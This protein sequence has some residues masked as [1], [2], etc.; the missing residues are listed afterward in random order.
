MRKILA[1][2]GIIL[3]VLGLFLFSLYNF[4]QK[5]NNIDYK[6]IIN[7]L[8]NRET[9]TW[10][11][12]WDEMVFEWDFSE[13]EEMIVAVWPNYDWGI[14]SLE[15]ETGMYLPPNSTQYFSDVKRLR[16][17]VTNI[18]NQKFSL[19]EIY[20]VYSNPGFPNIFQDYFG[21]IN[22]TGALSLDGDYPKAGTIDGKGAVHLGKAKTNGVYRITFSMEPEWVRDKKIADSNN[23]VLWPHPISPPHMIRL[24][25]SKEDTIYPYK[26]LFL[27][28]V[29][30]ST[31][32]LGGIALLKSRQPPRKTSRKKK[33]QKL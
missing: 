5:N 30:V 18:G 7:E 22:D 17:N 31:I 9:Y 29:G 28:P 24:Y 4:S 6:E 33:H 26:S 11:I 20:Y 21:V 32:A 3:I 23:T 8:V 13:G 1:I 12:S 16:V 19:I 14:P 2:G 15:P 10:E 25:K 27:L